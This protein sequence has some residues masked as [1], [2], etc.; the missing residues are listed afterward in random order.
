VAVQQEVQ[1]AQ[2]LFFLL[3]HQLA[4]AA[5]V[6]VKQVQPM[7]LLVALAVAAVLTRLRY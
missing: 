5:V 1:T 7:A 2:I 3:L 4:V 6:L